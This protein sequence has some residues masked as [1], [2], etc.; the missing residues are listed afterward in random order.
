MVIPGREEATGRGVGILCLKLLSRLGR[1]PQR[2][3]RRNSRD[4]VMWDSHTARFL[5]LADCK[6]VAVSDLTGAY[7]KPARVLIFRR[8]GSVRPSGMTAR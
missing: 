8:N 3:S 5:Q 1:D 6:I 2:D 7:F 4:L